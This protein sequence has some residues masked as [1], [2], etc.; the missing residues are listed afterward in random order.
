MRSRIFVTAL[1]LTALPLSSPIGPQRASAAGPHYVYISDTD[2]TGTRRGTFVYRLPLNAN[3][4]FLWTIGNLYGPGA[5]A[6]GAGQVYVLVAGDVKNEQGTLVF[7]QT[8]NG[9]VSWVLKS[10][11]L[12]EM[13]AVDQAGDIFQGQT[14]V[15]GSSASYEINVFLHPILKSSVP[16]FTMNTAVNQSGGTSTRGMAFDADG[17]LWVKDDDNKKAVIAWLLSITGTPN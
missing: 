8:A 2:N 16:A 13:I 1:V 3:S 9:P 7:E 4:R 5:V 17:N 15:N 12:P 6:F 10:S 14:N 11:E